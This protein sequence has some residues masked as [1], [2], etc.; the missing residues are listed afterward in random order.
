MLYSKA[1]VQTYIIQKQ[2]TQI[3]LTVSLLEQS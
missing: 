1:N 2:Q 3:A